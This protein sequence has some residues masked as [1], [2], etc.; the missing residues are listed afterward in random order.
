[1]VRT[2]AYSA[3]F[4]KET[5]KLFR[6]AVFLGEGHNGIV[7][8]LPENK[9][10]KIFQEAKVCREEADILKSVSK[11]SYFPRVYNIGEFYM[12]REVVSGERLDHFIKRN[13]MSKDLAK[14][15]YKLISEFKKIKFTKLDARC[16]DIYVKDNLSLRV[17]DPKDC[18]KKRITYPR[19]LMKGLKKID[20]LDSFL[21]YIKDIDKRCGEEWEKKM[22]QYLYECE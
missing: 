7:Y 13:G 3:D 18:Y 2:Y 6:K 15:I 12:V 10:I 4:D 14:N 19:H 20:C 22:K 5:E 21:G 9:A 1:M 17:I 11:S 16:R 8:E